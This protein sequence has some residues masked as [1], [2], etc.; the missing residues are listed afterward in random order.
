M[1]ATGSDTVVLREAIVAVRI[2]RPVLHGLVLLAGTLLCAA[3]SSIEIPAASPNPFTGHRQ[4]LAYGYLYYPLVVVPVLASF[5]ASPLRWVEQHAR[6]RAAKVDAALY[7]LAGSLACVGAV[8]V[9]LLAR[10]PGGWI[11]AL[12][13]MLGVL[14]ILG[15][16]L[17]LLTVQW[18]WLPAFAYTAAGLTLE[19]SPLWV[20]NREESLDR[21]IT[22]AALFAIVVALT[23]AGLL[24]RAD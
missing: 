11:V 10:D 12:T 6:P 23:H 17:R 18:A 16:C 21:L 7:A 1:V 2:H 22:A 9:A 20:L 14:V 3:V 15:L 5:T 4:H 13:N 24:R 8:I 19:V